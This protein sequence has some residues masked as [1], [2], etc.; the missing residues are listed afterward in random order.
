MTLE[1]GD[2]RRNQV[3]V[4]LTPD[5]AVV[6]DA[7][8]AL[9]RSNWSR[10]VHEIVTR[11]LNAELKDPLVQA[12]IKLHVRQDSREQAGIT[13]IDMRRAGETEGA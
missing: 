10:A 1:K 13:R 7:R 8:V 9:D 12:Q 11:A 3:L 6:L 5:Q 4:R 2:R